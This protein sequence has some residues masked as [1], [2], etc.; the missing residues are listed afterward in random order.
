MKTLKCILLCFLVA[1]AT[2]YCLC[3]QRSGQ[4]TRFIRSASK[5]PALAQQQLPDLDRYLEKKMKK[6]G[7]LGMQVAFVSSGNSIWQGNYGVKEYGTTKEVDA[8]TLFMIAS[9]SKPI[10]ALGVLKLVDQGKVQLDDPVNSYLPF[11]V[12]NPNYP[13][14]AISIRMLLAHVSSLKDNWSVLTPLYTLEEGGDSPLPL[15]EFLADYLVEGKRFYNAEANFLNTEAA[16][17]FQYSNVGYALLGYL[18]ECVAEKP[19]KEFMQTELFDPLGMNDTYWFLGDIP[20]ENIARPHELPDKE[21]DLTEPKIHKHYGYP[22]YPDG[23][24]RTTASDYGRFLSLILNQ[25]R[26]NGEQFVKKELIDEFTSVQFPDVNKHQA[27]AWNYNEF[28]NF[29]YYL[30][31]PR[32]PSHTGADPGVATA[33]SLDPE[34]KTGAIL[35]T[36]SPPTRFTGQKIFYQEMMKRLLKEARKYG[37]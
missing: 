1:S 37:R 16:T 6:A 35:F 10:T 24:V 8:N 36:N 9:C 31:M 20:H 30:L 28:E 13:H 2:E 5:T 14:E 22:D 17:E 4:N 29:I 12:V 25:G 34:Y 11:P 18:I 15:N 3:Q 26:I 23:Q 19:F 32:L 7:L 21:N 27:I 33:V